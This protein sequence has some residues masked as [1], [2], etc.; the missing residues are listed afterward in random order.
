ME[1]ESTD[2]L[3]TEAAARGLLDGAVGLGELVHLSLRSNIIKNSNK[4]HNKHKKKEKG[5]TREKKGNEG[6]EGGRGY[7]GDFAE[8]EKA[9][10]VLLRSKAIVG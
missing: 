10:G 5:E 8:E 4:S 7:E 3:D 6:K 2:A 1:K 9:G